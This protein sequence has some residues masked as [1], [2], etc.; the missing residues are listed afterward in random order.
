MSPK[1]APTHAPDIYHAFSI[2][3]ERERES[4]PLVLYH[5]FAGQQGTKSLLRAV[6]GKEKSLEKGSNPR[7]NC[8]RWGPSRPDPL[9]GGAGPG[10]VLWWVDPRVASL[11]Q[12]CAYASMPVKECRRRSVHGR[13]PLQTVFRRCSASYWPTRHSL[14][15]VRPTVASSAYLLRARPRGSSSSEDRQEPGPPTT[16]ARESG[17]PA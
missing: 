5:L 1:R 17:P 13:Q 12:C 10:G 14:T 8:H 16:A 11:A 2:I 3:R 7:Q 4:P 6:H 15:G 9:W